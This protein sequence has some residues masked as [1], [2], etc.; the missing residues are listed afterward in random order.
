VVKS[1]HG[2][3]I[4]RGASEHNLKGLN[5]VLPKGKLVVFTG[6][7]GSGKSSLAFD[8]LYAEGQRRY[9]ESLSSYARQFL[10]QMD[11]PKYDSIRGLAP[12]ISIEQ[13]TA[14]HNPRST[15]GTVTEIYDYLRVLY[16]RAG[17]LHCPQC[18][19]VV[20]RTDAA[21]I[22]RSIQAQEKGTKILVMA[23]I[24]RNRKGTF[25]EE[26]EDFK[27]QGFTRVRINEEVVLIEDAPSL[28]KNKK[29]NLDVV[30][31]RL[32][33][34]PDVGPRLTDSVETA[35]RIGMGQVLVGVVD[36]WEKLY[37][38]AHHCAYCDLSLP[39]PTPALF[40]FNS[41]VGACVRCNGLGTTH[42][43]AVERLVPDPSKTLNEYCIRLWGGA[44]SVISN[45]VIMGLSKKY[46]I[47]MDVP[48]TDIP[49]PMRDKILYG[50]GDDVFEVRWDRRKGTATFP[51][52]FEGVVPQIRR[53]FKETS[54]NARM[55]HYLQFL[56]ETDC[57]DC[58]GQRLGPAARAA[59][60]ADRSLPELASHT[61]VSLHK[62][63][64]DMKLT[65]NAAIIA[66]EV[67][68]EVR[69]RLG[70]LVNVGLEYLTLDRSA[71]T[72]SGG[73]AQR[74]RLA[75]Q[76]GSELTGVLYILDEP[77]VGLH[78]RDNQRLLKTLFHMRD[79]GN[80]VIVVEHDRETIE[81]AD[82]VVDFG[83]GAGRLGGNVVA[84]G[85]LKKILQCKDSLT[86]LY[87]SGKRQIEIPKKRRKATQK[88]LVIK[89]AR[90]HNLK[91]IDVAFPVGCFN[92]VTGV[93]GAGKST[94]INTI[95]HPALSQKLHG[96]S[97]TPG[98][99]KSMTG[100]EHFDKVV[101][102][103][104]KP[105]GRT[106]RSNPAT[107]TKVF[108]PIRQVFAATRESRTYGYKPSRFSFNVKGGRCEAC[109]G[110]GVIR[111]EMHFLADVFVRCE[112]C[113]GKRFND[114]TLRVLFKGHT[115]FDVLE[116]TVN[117]A[118]Q[119]FE[120]HPKIRRVLSTLV[121]VGLGYIGLGQPA[122]TLSG[123]EAQRV[124][125]S[126]ELAKKATGR[127]LYV[128]DEPTTGLHFEDVQKLLSVIHRLVDAG[129]T[130]IV[131]EH[132]LDV[133]KT[134][135]HVLDLGPEGGDA[136]GY[137]VASG[138]PEAVAKVAQ[139]HT[140]RYLAKI[141]ASN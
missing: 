5:L 35:L 86:G 31:D 107:Y 132:N 95:V 141:L 125:L 105:I 114:A 87:L 113:K 122:T 33:V 44:H 110:A 93:S 25:A 106:P 49:G 85:P 4:I 43:V 11:K 138:T 75:S 76:V 120:H 117:E 66:K 64:Q 67:L 112:S 140:G 57:P 2:E 38:E 111:I 104:Q 128:L 102:I 77:T 55:V 23:P 99:F 124:K 137:L 101:V 92:V 131:I 30:V 72:L 134:A 9:V 89:G 20:E 84:E 13:R 59:R 39:E 7:S 19:R 78:P 126:R 119:L 71:S 15:V 70:F 27:S 97:V 61:I 26:L 81:S 46:K 139:S 16:A 82:H 58:Q 94:L 100:Q 116:M 45:A 103:N 68:R 98:R 32:I 90:E 88:A 79:I 12:T 69:A 136:G 48:W 109:R 37:S 54:S 24:A 18:E 22:V 129:N 80:T 65:G 118:A 56:H 115:I 41:P 130:V 133:I 47:P 62:H 3:L 123:G 29:H 121:E 51:M 50:T 127:T 1:L 17:T 14:S 96:E 36:G 60:L 52:S 63:F 91:G 83:P 73:E 6:V 34:R 135:D 42:E 8:T 74:I 40:S 108:D 53:L 21:Q 10:G 28:N